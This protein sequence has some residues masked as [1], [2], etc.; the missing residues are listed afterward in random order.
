[1]NE[2]CV[3]CGLQVGDNPYNTYGIQM[4]CDQC[5]AVLCDA[6]GDWNS[7]DE[8]LCEECMTKDIS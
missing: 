6:C 7:S 3:V 8:Y 2:K 5:H 4:E 1:M